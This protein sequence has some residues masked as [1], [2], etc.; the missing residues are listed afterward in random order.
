[1]STKTYAL[2]QLR[3]TGASALS[4]L[5]I[6]IRA[7]LII[8]KRQMARLLLLPVPTVL[9]PHPL[10]LAFLSPDILTLRARDPVLAW[11]QEAADGETTTA[12]KG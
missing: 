7:L 1:M 11:P 2:L 10:M 5:S 8:L 4:P 9:A 12:G 6:P 3:P